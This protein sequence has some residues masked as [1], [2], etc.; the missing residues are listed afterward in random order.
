MYVF[1]CQKTLCCNRFSSH[2]D[3]TKYEE[4]FPW[5]ELL[6]YAYINALDNAYM[7]T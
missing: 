5:S 6:T 2:F 7:N 4:N 1:H 3:R